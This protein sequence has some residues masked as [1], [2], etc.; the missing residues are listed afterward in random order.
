MI[1]RCCLGQR[2]HLP[3][4]RGEGEGPMTN[5]EVYESRPVENEPR[6]P[7]YESTTLDDQERH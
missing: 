4:W 7:Y 5:Y 2:C 1:V 3:P 6:P